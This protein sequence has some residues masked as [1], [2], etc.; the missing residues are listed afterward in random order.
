[1]EIYDGT[2]PFSE[3]LLDALN[4]GITEPDPREDLSGRDVQRKLLILARKAGFE[5]SLEDIDC[6]NLVPADLQRL[7][8]SEFLGRANELDQYFANALAQASSESACIRYVARFKNDEKNGMS[9]QVQLATL[10]LTH[11]FA[12]L[13]PGDNIFQIVSQWYQNNPLMIRGAG[14]GREVT[15]GGLHSD[16]VNICQ[17]LANKQ[18]QVNIKGIN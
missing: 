12:N 15:A 11:A 5:L 7:P 8:L 3:L 2:R 16:L 14:A 10:P 9:A 18:N 17:Q 6:Q 1:L 4:K 13:T